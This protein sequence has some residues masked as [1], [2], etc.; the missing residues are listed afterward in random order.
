MVEKVELVH[1]RL[2]GVGLFGEEGTITKQA[3]P[4]SGRGEEILNEMGMDTKFLVHQCFGEVLRAVLIAYSSY[5][6]RPLCQQK[7]TLTSGPLLIYF[8]PWRRN[9][10][11]DCGIHH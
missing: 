8:F 7:P 1:S 11:S 6:Q 5:F 2:V 3:Q 4:W 9:V 10:L